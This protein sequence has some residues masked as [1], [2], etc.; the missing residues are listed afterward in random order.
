MVKITILIPFYNEAGNI[1]RQLEDTLSTIK[2]IEKCDFHI[3][4]VDDGSTDDSSLE[5]KKFISENN[6]EM[7]TLIVHEKNSGKTNAFISAFEIIKTDYVIF[8]D[9]DYQDDPKEIPLPHEFLTNRELMAQLYPSFA[10]GLAPFFTLN[11]SEYSDFLTFQGGLNP[12]TGGL[13]L[14]DEAHHH[15]AIAVLFLVSGHMYRTNWGIGHSMKEILEAHKGPFTG[16]GHKGL[17]EIL[18]TSWHAQLAINLAM[19]G[20][21]SIIVA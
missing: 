6:K 2:K 18:T 13:W 4:L 16:E 12:V 21:L 10:K 19:V 17:Y 3:V 20:S 1:V 9:G 11:W 8:M 14:S 15:L 7:F 5:V